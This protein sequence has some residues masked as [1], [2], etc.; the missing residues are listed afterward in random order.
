MGN[1]VRPDKWDGHLNTIERLRCD[2]LIEVC[3][4]VNG[5]D[6]WGMER[7]IENNTVHSDNLEEHNDFDVVGD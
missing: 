7:D 2:G 3:Y 4:E 1:A 5:V 6:V